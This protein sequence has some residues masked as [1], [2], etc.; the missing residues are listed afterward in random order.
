MLTA[1]IPFLDILVHRPWKFSGATTLPGFRLDHPAQ[2]IFPLQI[3]KLTCASSISSSLR[4]S[5]RTL[6][7]LQK[8]STPRFDSICNST[9]VFRHRHRILADLV[10][11]ALD[12]QKHPSSACTRQKRSLAQPF[13]GRNQAT[14]GSIF[15]RHPSQIFKSRTTSH[16]PGNSR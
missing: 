2:P 16:S 12:F 7:E 1:F 8:L 10:E 14:S 4:A 13:S 5:S 15:G 3:G 9:H 11:R 6:Q